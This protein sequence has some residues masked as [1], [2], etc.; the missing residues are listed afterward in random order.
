MSWSLQLGV[1]AVTIIRDP[2]DFAEGRA[3]AGDT[4]P[5]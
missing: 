1:E 5:F 2:D 4:G 3:P